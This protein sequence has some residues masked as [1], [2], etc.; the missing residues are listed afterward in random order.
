MIFKIAPVNNCM[1]GFGPCPS[2]DRLSDEISEY[3]QSGI[4]IVL[5]LLEEQEAAIL[6]LDNEEKLVRKA[7]LEFINFPIKDGSVPGFASYTKF[8]DL[9]YPQLNTHA[10]LYVHCHHGIGRSSLLVAG[11][12][13]K[14]GAGYDETLELIAKKR[15]LAVPETLSQKK[16]LFTYSKTRK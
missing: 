5:S 3:K 9:L 1:I 8:L 4:S 13:I 14:S 12:L 7:G 2:H 15:G 10:Q 6:K 11:L 16:F